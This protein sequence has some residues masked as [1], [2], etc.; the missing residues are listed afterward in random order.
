M[1]LLHTGDWHVGKTVRGRSRLDEHRAVFEEIVAIAAREAVDLVVVAGDLFEHSA[2]SPESQQLVWSTLLAL[3]ATGA[4]VVAVAGN[5]DN[6]FAFDAWS[7]LCA[8]AGFHLLGHPRGPQAGGL[9]ELRTTGG[10]LVR[11]AALPF[12]SQ[13]YAVHARDLFELSSSDA[14]GTYEADYRQLV[15][16]L[17]GAD[18]ATAPG[19]AAGG[20]AGDGAVSVLVGHC[21]IVH[22]SFGGGE[23]QAQSIFDYVVPASVF[24]AALHY[25]ALGHLHR[26]QSIPSA[27]P[28]W[29][30]GSPIQ[31][32]FGEEHHEPCVLVVEAT[33]SSPARVREVH[34]ASAARLRTVEGSLDELRA[35][36]A[37]RGDEPAWLRV[38]V[39]EPV[40]A[41]LAD[42]VRALLP[43]AVDV[44][45]VHE[46]EG[47]APPSRAVTGEQSPHDLFAAF[48]A[49]RSIDDE[50]VVALFDDLLEELTTGSEAR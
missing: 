48:C 49:G 29:Y 4:Q 6:P 20:A 33:A 14:G 37:A 32:D 34:L 27:C 1:K 3:R 17:C 11:V 18:A 16:R 15:A 13:R 26:T 9:I 5:H 19:A 38:R 28:G 47:D 39:R 10:E 41:G 30:A 31:V 7:P 22:A 40:R 8:A 43:A 45:V 44:I 2:P 36:A 35:Y 24:P 23:R 12:V 21:T 46:P 50:R 42:E 25:V